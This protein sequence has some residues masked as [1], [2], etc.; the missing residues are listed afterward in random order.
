MKISHRTT[1]GPCVSD[2]ELDKSD[3]ESVVF[4]E[5]VDEETFVENNLTNRTDVDC[6]RAICLLCRTNKRDEIQSTFAI[7]NS[8]GAAT[9]FE[10][11]QNSD[12]SIF[13][14]CPDP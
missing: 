3:E 11:A 12:I 10:I 8:Q 9:K 7:S 2:T 5:E 4:V 13:L 14:N 6:A 1:F